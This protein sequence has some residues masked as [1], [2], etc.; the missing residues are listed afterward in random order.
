MPEHARIQQWIE[1]NGLSTNALAKEV[2]MS[3]IPVFRM[4]RGDR[5]ISDGFK[6][7]FISRYGIE[8]AE[9]LFDLPQTGQPVI[10]EPQ[11]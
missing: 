7:R 4:M 9:T 1:K 11:P 10:S 2:G 8:V 6:L 5:R 3:Y